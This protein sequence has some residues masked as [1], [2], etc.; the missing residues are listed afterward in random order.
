[1]VHLYYWL[2]YIWWMSVRRLLTQ[3]WGRPHV[4]QGGSVDLDLSSEMVSF[5]IGENELVKLDVLVDGAL[6]PIV[7]WILAMMPYTSQ[8]HW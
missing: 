4:A 1:M 7:W 8:Q 3:G 2:A 6:A 5:S